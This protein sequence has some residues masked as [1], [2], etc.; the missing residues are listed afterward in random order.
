MYDLLIQNARM[1]DG[2]GAPWTWG[3]LAVRDGKALGVRAGKV[4]KR[5]K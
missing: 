5:K 2:T 4:L 3:S 1:I